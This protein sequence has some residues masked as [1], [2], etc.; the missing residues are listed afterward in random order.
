[1]GAGLLEKVE[2]EIAK[3]NELRNQVSDLDDSVTTLSPDI[4]KNAQ[5][6]VELDAFKGKIEPMTINLSQEITALKTDGQ[7]ASETA[8]TLKEYS[9]KLDEAIKV[10]Q[11]NEK[12]TAKE[13]HSMKDDS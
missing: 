3:L 6:I 1:M 13:L 7:N 10:I 2:D 5:K 9:A 12:K 8:E 4:T 11:E